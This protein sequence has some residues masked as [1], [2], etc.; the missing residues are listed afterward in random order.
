MSRLGNKP[1]T[2]PSGVSVDVT[3]DNQVTVKGPK[4]TLS[5]K[6]DA[7]FNIAQQAQK[8]IVALPEGEVSRAAIMKHGLWRMLTHNMVVGVSTGYKKTLQIIGVG[9]VA[10]VEQGCLHLRVG[11][12][13]DIII[14]PPKELMV[15]VEVKKGKQPATYIHVEGIDKELVGQFSAK[16]REQKPPEPYASKRAN[17]PKGIRYVDELV[18]E[19]P[20]KSGK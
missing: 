11:K 7:G 13:H 18:I 2:I 17:T 19:K 10:N 5:L 20:K 8:I 6:V 3:K 15:S 14:K 1:I 9:F 12:S 16:V 4:G